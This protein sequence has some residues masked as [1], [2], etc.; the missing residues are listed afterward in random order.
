MNQALEDK[1]FLSFNKTMK[2]WY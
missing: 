1:K 2:I